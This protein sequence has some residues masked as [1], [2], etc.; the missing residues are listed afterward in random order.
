MVVFPVQEHV[1]L[2]QR[3]SGADGLLPVE[4]VTFLAVVLHHLAA[5][6]HQQRPRTT[7]GIADGIA[8]LWIQK[9]GHKVGDLGRG[10]VLTSLLTAVGGKLADQVLVGVANHVEVTD[11]AW[12]QVELRLGK[13]LQQVAQ[14]GVFLLLFAEAIAV[15]A[16]VLEHALIAIFELGAVGFFQYMQ[17]LINSLAVSRLVTSFIEGIEAGLFGQHKALALHHLFDKLWRVA[18]LLLVAVVMVLPDIRDVLQEQHGEDEI[19]VGIG[20]D[21][22]TEDIAGAPNGV[23]DNVLIDLFGH[24]GCFLGVITGMRASRGISI[25]LFK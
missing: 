10:I 21:G 5:A 6:F 11:P 23:V 12:F 4:G 14:N 17:C 8:E 19:L 25:G 24:K 13:F 9:F 3:P 15:E 18:V 2:G 1:H 22:A 20:A 7:G 16:D